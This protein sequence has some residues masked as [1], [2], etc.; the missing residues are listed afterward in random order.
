MEL[1]K[2]R[3]DS[4]MGTFGTLTML[5]GLAAG[6]FAGV[7]L[8]SPDQPSASP[9]QTDG[10][11]VDIVHNP[12][13]FTEKD[14]PAELA[15]RAVCLGVACPSSTGT[16]TLTD[17]VGVV[18]TYTETADKDE[19]IVF[20][21]EP[22]LLADGPVTYSGTFTGGSDDTR[23]TWP[24]VASAP[25]SLQAFTPDRVIDLG[26]ADF[27][28]NESNGTRVF[29][30][31]WGT[32]PDQLGV[33]DAVGPSSFDVE[34]DGTIH[35]L[36]LVNS[37]LIRFDGT[38]T[39]HAVKIALPRDFPDIAAEDD[40]TVD[41]LYPNGAGTGRSYVDR[42]NDQGTLIE[43]VPVVGRRSYNIRRQSDT[44]RVGADQRVTDVIE[45]GKALGEDRQE[46][47]TT[48][49]LGRTGSS[50]VSKHVSDNVVRVA[51]VDDRTGRA[52]TSWEVTG[53]TRLG[54]IVLAEP[55]RGGVLLVQSQFTDQRSR[56]VTVYLTRTGPV[57]ITPLP[58][59]RFI[60]V[61]AGSE[62]RLVGN[63][64]Y[65]ARSTAQQF[66]IA[67]YPLKDLGVQ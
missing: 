30:A 44:V 63:M 48:S 62:F 42:F 64:L 49:V 3:G 28:A 45:N 16:L 18:R 19:S 29:K 17:S 34:P 50:V 24:D 1:P 22:E 60:E 43:T 35:V 2:A 20:E 7:A 8:A 27:D 12:P 26:T 58:D 37:R 52:T 10:S 51:L 15:F 21:V 38:G 5:L 56:Y 53:D 65:A 40:G 32:S 39:M 46:G 33:D 59:R 61:T 57:R 14:R 36:D 13:I 11:L 67:S 55:V 54:P 23:L 47:R 4:R 6:G 9:P 31:T 66:E 25:A 41:V